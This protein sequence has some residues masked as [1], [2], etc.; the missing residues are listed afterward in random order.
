MSE[1]RFD[2]YKRFIQQIALLSYNNFESISEFIGDI[3]LPQENFKTILSYVSFKT[4]TLNYYYFFFLTERTHLLQMLKKNKHWVTG[5]KISNTIN[6]F[7]GFNKKDLIPHL[8][9]IAQLFH[10]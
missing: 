2:Y 9:K 7:T 8:S 5:C 6:L 10:L 3:N 1:E 4:V